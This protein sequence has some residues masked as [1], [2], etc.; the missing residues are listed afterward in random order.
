[1]LNMG[2]HTMIIY[3]ALCLLINGYRNI[4]SHKDYLLELEVIFSK[5]RGY[6]YVWGV[7]FIGLLL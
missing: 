6:V 4:Y 2:I 1:M 5:K 3:F 7:T